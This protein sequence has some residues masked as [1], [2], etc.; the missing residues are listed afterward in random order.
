VPSG[1]KFSELAQ[2]LIVKQGGI[3]MSSLFV[4]DEDPLIVTS[5][6]LHGIQQRTT[7]VDGRFAM[8]VSRTYGL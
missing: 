7:R 2:S 6:I 3:L 4:S 1:G 5:N 8:D